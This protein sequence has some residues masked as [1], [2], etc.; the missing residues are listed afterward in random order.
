M[1]LHGVPSFSAA[2]FLSCASCSPSRRG[3]PA[4][5]QQ[6]KFEYEKTNLVMAEVER[7][8][9]RAIREGRCKMRRHWKQLGGFGNK[10]SPKRKSYKGLSQD[11]WD[12]LCNYFGKKN[13]WKYMKRILIISL[14]GHL[15]V[16]MD[17]KLWFNIITQLLIL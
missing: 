3:S 4:P 10:D 6:N 17:R 14:I 7:L 16:H 11:D 15:K 8:A 13:K 5:S 9:M 12:F 2:I 1:I